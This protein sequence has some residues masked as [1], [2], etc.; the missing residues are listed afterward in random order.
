VTIK[1]LIGYEVQP[2][3]TREE[4]DRWL[5]EVHVP[6]LLQNPHLDR[7]V[8]NTV[9]EQVRTTSDGVTP[10]TQSMSLYRVAELHFADHEALER[11]RRWFDDHPI[12]PERGPGGRSDFRFYVVCEVEEVERGPRAA[13]RSG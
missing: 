5:Y 9:V 13:P 12:P 8:F 1:L 4:Y 2:G 3:L 11:Y 7:I 10:A 6:D